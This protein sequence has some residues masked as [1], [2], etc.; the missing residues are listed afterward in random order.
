MY[1]SP[2]R[3]PTR[4]STSAAAN[5][6]A[7]ASGHASRVGHASRGRVTSATDIGGVEAG[8]LDAGEAL[9][10]KLVERVVVD[11][12]PGLLED[13]EAARDD[14]RHAAP[15]EPGATAVHRAG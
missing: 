1:G 5:R 2:V 8:G 3:R 12:R 14:D 9:G 11:V 13:P 10:R 4:R 7:S 6:P 15:R